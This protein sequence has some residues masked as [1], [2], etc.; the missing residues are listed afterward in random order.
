MGINT[1]LGL[2]GA[3]TFSQPWVMTALF[4]AFYLTLGLMALSRP[5]AAMVLYFGTSIMNPQASYPILMDI[6]LAK[7]VAG[8][9]LLVC[10]LNLRKITVRFPIMLLPMALF[11]V[12]V[13][14]SATGALRPDLADK[15]LEEF[16]KVGLMATLTVWAVRTRED[17]AFFFWGILGSLS[18]NVLK[19]LVET[20]TKSVWVGISGVAGWIGDS[21]DWALALAMGLPLFYT[22]LILNWGKGWKIRTVCG[23]AAI[24]ALLT[25]TLTYSRGGFLAAAASGAVFLLMDRKPSRSVLVGLLIAVVVAV[26]MPRS[27]LD[28]METIFGLQG[29]AESAWEK[30]VDQS[31]EYTGAERVYY[32]R[33]AYEVMRDYP[34]HGV[35]WGNF[36]QEFKR[37][38]N[39]KEGLVAHSTWFQV[40]AEAG[41]VALA[42]YV[43]MLLAAMGSAFRTWR[44]ARREKDTWREWQ[45]RIIV[46][47]LVAF[48][49]GGTFLSREN[50]ELLFIYIAMAAALARLAP[51][52]QAAAATRPAGRPVRNFVPLA[53]PG[54]KESLA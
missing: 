34:L 27:Y 49:V 23:L 29:T 12:M 50:S 10:L 18:Y 6:P 46:C 42:L 45:A 13:V 48:C 15:R 35:G 21:N 41:A 54:K 51:Q 1:L 44:K 16:L 4:L 2:F 5:V 17:Y 30:Q 40:G 25:L 37:R 28:K 31:Q 8:L 52:E 43:L 39:L 11:L 19:N 24:G 53:R 7:I 47:G 36:I 32:W 14:A 26:Y 9:G 20:Q 33:I 3:L 22:A 38:E